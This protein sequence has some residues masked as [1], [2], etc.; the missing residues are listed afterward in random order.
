MYKICMV[1]YQISSSL[2]S[3]SN[4]LFKSDAGRSI[5]SNFFF[6]QDGKSDLI[7]ASEA[8]HELVMFNLLDCGA[9]VNFKHE[10]CT[11]TL[12]IENQSVQ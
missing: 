12:D 11:H 6:V 1:C 5:G 10:V 8:G 3:W 2:F 7:L 4:F 9:E